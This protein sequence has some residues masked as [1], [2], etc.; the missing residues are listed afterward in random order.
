MSNMC[1]K[2]LLVVA[3]ESENILKGVKHATHVNSVWCLSTR[4]NVSRD[5]TL[6]HY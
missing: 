6:N 1:L 3:K 4:V 2:E 5:V